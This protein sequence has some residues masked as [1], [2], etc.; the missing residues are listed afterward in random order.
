MTFNSVHLIKKP[1]GSSTWTTAESLFTL[2]SL[3]TPDTMSINY[4]CN[5]SIIKDMQLKYTKVTK[6]FFLLN[7]MQVVCSVTKW[8]SVVS[9]TRAHWRGNRNTKLQ[10]NTLTING[11]DYC[12]YCSS[13]INYFNI[14]PV[15]SCILRI[16]HNY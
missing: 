15:S 12:N 6:P 1:P 16:R 8:V 10:Q 9:S 14:Q 4:D 5:Q 11:E 2:H 7:F 13:L 3:Q